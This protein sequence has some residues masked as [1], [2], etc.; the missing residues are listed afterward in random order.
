MHCDICCS[1]PLHDMLK[2]HNQKH[3]GF[4]TV[5]STRVKEA[6][7]RLDYGRFIYDDRTN[8]KHTYIL[9]HSGYLE[10]L[11]YKESPESGDS[12]VLISSTGGSS[13]SNMVNCGVYLFTIS[14]MYN[15]P[16]FKDYAEKY[17]RIVAISKDDSQE[18]SLS[19][20]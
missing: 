6:E 14:E 7:D 20:L 2:F 8:G 19:Q 4:L 12:N 3:S 18:R 11:H 16:A 10:I 9:S 15:E 17:G 13:L 5:M 1:F